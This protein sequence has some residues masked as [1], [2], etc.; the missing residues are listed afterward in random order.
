MI[1][2]AL[3]FCKFDQTQNSYNRVE[4]YLMYNQMKT[5]A[6]RP[7]VHPVPLL[8]T[9]PATYQPHSKWSHV[10]KDICC[11]VTCKTHNK[12]HNIAKYCYSYKHNEKKRINRY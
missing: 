3:G 9:H 10:T 5:Q 8:F 1:F 4:T 7:C 6:L 12:R 11:I 2:K